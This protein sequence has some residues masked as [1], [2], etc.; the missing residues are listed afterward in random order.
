[1]ELTFCYIVYIIFTLNSLIFSFLLS[2]KL[3]GNKLINNQ[4]MHFSLMLYIHLPFLKY[5]VKAYLHNYTFFIYC[6][7]LIFRKYNSY[8]LIFVHPELFKPSSTITGL[9]PDKIPLSLSLCLPLSL[10]LSL[11]LT[12]THSW[13]TLLISVASITKFNCKRKSKDPLPPYLVQFPPPAS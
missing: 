8:S 9:G 6:F 4:N 10:S 13:C 5:K 2:N 12:H 3:F 7:H 11:A 1:M